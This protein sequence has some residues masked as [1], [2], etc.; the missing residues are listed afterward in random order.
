MTNRFYTSEDPSA[1]V[2]TGQAGALT[3]LLDACLVTGYGSGGT[4]KAAAGW[5]IAFTDVNKRVYTMTGGTGFSMYM[6]DSGD[7][8]ANEGYVIGYQQATG[9]NA[10]VAPWPTPAQM[11]T[12]LTHGVPWRKSETTDATVRRWKLAADANTAMLLV[13]TGLVIGGVYGWMGFIFGDIGGAS[14]NDGFACLNMGNRT[15]NLF[16]PD[17][18]PAPVINFGNTGV[19]VND[20]EY[21]GQWLAAAAV[22]V[23]TS[24][25]CGKLFDLTL[26][27]SSSSLQNGTT[28][29][30]QLT[31]GMGGNYVNSLVFPSPN[32]ADGAIYMSPVRINSGNGIRGHLKGV[33]ASLHHLP[34]N[35]GDTFTVATGNLAGKSFIAVA[36][37][38][39][40]GQ[41]GNR[42]AI[43]QVFIETSSTWS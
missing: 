17:G 18:R 33:W 35:D 2:L 11:S 4:A 13:Q 8:V 40:H 41:A 28:V 26:M 39:T 3:T 43:G 12:G 1:P 32:N 30:G 38:M 7:V 37:F 20:V 24:V 23:P 29:D 9:L 22:G 36:T 16:Q 5:T 31:I 14:A 10:G 34:L 42:S 6:D 27:G 19:G 21:S 15:T 25:Q